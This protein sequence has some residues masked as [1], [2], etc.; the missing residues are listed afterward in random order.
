MLIRLDQVSKSFD[1]RPLLSEVCFQ[2]N[3]GEKVA[4]VGKNGCGKTT[5][6]RLINAEIEP[7][8]GQIIRYPH[9]RIGFL[10]QIVQFD[11][12]KSVF[13]EAVSVFRALEELGEEIERLEGEIEAKA[14]QS[15][16]QFLLDRYAEFQTRWE[17]A[18]GYAYRYQ[19]ESVLFGLGFEE[20]DLTKSVAELS[21]GELNRLNLAKLLLG[22]P[23]LLLLDEPTNHLDIAA[24]QW[25]E[26][27]LRDY[28]YAFILI[29]HDRY[30]LDATVTKILELSHGAL[31]E[32]SGNYS[33]YLEERERHLLNY[34]KS[35]ERQQE[36]IERTED[37]IR[38]NI[39]GQK[40]KQ[41]QSRRKMLE[42]MERMET[43]P[44]EKLSVRFGFEKA[45]PSGNVVVRLS[46]L[47]TGYKGKVLTHGINLAVFRGQKIGIAGPNG[48]GKTT[49]LRT[50]LGLQ[51]PLRGS[52]TRGHNVMMGYYAQTLSDLNLS[53]TVLEEMRSVAPLESDATLRGYLARF[54]FRADEVFRSVALLSGGEKSRLS[55]AKLIFGKA[56]TLVLDEPTNHLDIPSCEALESSLKAFPG[57]VILVSHDRYL[58][59]HLAERIIYLDEKGGYIHFEGTYKE[60]EDQSTSRSFEDQPDSRGDPNME[61]TAEYPSSCD[62][63][64]KNERNKIRS[65]CENIEQEI[66][67]LEENMKMILDKLNEPATAEDHILFKQVNDRYEEL[68][69]R[70]EDLYSE[71][72]DSL[73]LLER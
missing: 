17:T 70:L 62:Q 47:D 21:G 9:L 39:A 67:Q 37:F 27:F 57:T 11:S 72:G 15:G 43:L 29:S 40:T 51:D 2:L 4:L 20:R 32:Y 61:I 65:R 7:D 66:R 34:Q 73:A 24:V 1:S 60:F 50:I 42:K 45:A 13:D 12:E 46:D 26:G 44:Q 23:N 10:H 31:A 6:F 58:L 52:V 38:R 71:W 36:F 8:S 19:T 48:S 56:N 41:A 69:A 63:I 59:S 30:F 28:P 49:L 55:L 18:G 14:K 16:L 35:Y 25:L 68:T 22:K 3:S 64:S 33:Q 54:L 53:L 5:L